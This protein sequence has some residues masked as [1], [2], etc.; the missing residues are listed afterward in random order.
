MPLHSLIS[1]RSCQDMEDWHVVKLLRYHD[2]N[3]YI[4]VCICICVLVCDVILFTY[5]YIYICYRYYTF[6]SKDHTI[7]VSDLYRNQH[8]P[9]EISNLESK[10]T[11]GFLFFLSSLSVTQGSSTIVSYKHKKRIDSLNPFLDC[12]KKIIKKK[13]FLQNHRWNWH[14]VKNQYILGTKINQL[15]ASS[16]SAKGKSSS[17]TWGMIL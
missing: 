14:Q 8:V 11:D 7:E 15:E 9:V 2:I 4:W 10:S 5:I 3:I 12:R 16:T 1:W 17:W 13:G 6:H